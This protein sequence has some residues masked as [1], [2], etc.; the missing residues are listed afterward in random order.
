MLQKCMVV[1]KRVLD[2]VFVVHYVGAVELSR[3]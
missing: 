3:F 2:N 1:G